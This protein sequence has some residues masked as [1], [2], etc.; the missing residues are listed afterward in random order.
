V[1]APAAVTT[2]AVAAVPV[3]GDRDRYPVLV[4][5]SGLYGFRSVS[6]FQIEE[7]VSQGYV[8][9][10]LD[11]PGVVATVRFPDGHQIDDLPFDV[12]DP[13]VD[14]SIEPQPTTPALNGVPQPDGGQLTATVT[15]TAPRKRAQGR[16][17]PDGRPAG[18]PR[19]RRH[20]RPS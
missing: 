7:L 11:Q 10:G 6:T 8:V 20:D 15:A 2:N 14:Q 5:L 16:T 17:T 19:I 1:A 4:F 12:I 9:V 13:L 3:A 18:R